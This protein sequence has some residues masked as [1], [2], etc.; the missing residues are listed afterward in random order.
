MRRHAVS[1]GTFRILGARPLFDV[2]G[3]GGTP[4]WSV[5]ASPGLPHLLA[6]VGNGAVELRDVR[7]PDRVRGLRVGAHAAGGRVVSRSV[8]LSAPFLAAGAA[9]GVA[10]V[11]DLRKAPRDDP[12]QRPL[13]RVLAASPA[14]SSPR[15]RPFPSR[16]FDHARPGGPPS[17]EVRQVA[18]ARGGARL[19]TACY[20]GTASAWA[21]SGPPAPR[22]VVADHRGHAVERIAV[23]G[24]ATLAS[25]DFTG[26]L[27]LS[28]LDEAKVA[29]RHL[30]VDGDA[31]SPTC[32]AAP[33]FDEPAA[34]V[35]LAPEPG[36][37]DAAS[38]AFRRGPPA[39]DAPPGA[40]R[41]AK[42]WRLLDAGRAR[43]GAFFFGTS[44]FLSFA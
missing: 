1:D 10:R 37:F 30:D 34:A 39:K 22:E 26:C 33:S 23:D 38:T 25:V 32:V 6:A 9:D 18:F 44:N 20:D 14:P 12:R 11:W 2:G 35:Y 17:R 41:G 8:A 7:A 21:V 4:A 40:D 3:P 42:T 31:G 15:H 36:A 19:L 13:L 5:A 24:D 16:E 27:K 43:S 28:R 29:V